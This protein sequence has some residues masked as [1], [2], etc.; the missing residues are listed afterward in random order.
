MAVGDPWE[1]VSIAGVAA[2][3]DGLPARWWIAGGWAIELFAGASIRDHDDV[4][5]AVLR[6]DQLAVQAH[7]DGWDL[8]VAHGG[9]LAPWPPGRLLDP[10]EHGIWARPSPASPWRLELL[11]DDVV[12]GQWVYRR[13]PVV[14]LPLERLGRTTVAGV[15]YLCPE[16]VL[17]YKSKRP[18]AADEH[19]ARVAIPRL[20][21]A[22]R[23]WL[24]AAIAADA[25]DHQWL[26]LLA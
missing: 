5:V 4:D 18:R 13:N 21:A 20:S 1:P 17:L 22:E 2:L 24:A 7:L 3:L 15:P 14:R 10:D 23:A 16:V 9:G 25:P 8:R 26:P 6:P 19:D 12:D 11:V